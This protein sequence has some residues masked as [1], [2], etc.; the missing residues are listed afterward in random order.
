[1]AIDEMLAEALQD[2]DLET[3]SDPEETDDA[4]TAGF[5]MTEVGASCPFIPPFLACSCCC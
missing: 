1:M 4:L 3:V 2:L 5:G